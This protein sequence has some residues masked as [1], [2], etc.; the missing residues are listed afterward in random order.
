MTLTNGFSLPGR[1][2]VDRAGEQPFPGPALPGDQHGGIRVLH[3]LD[4]VEDPSDPRRLSDDVAERE[5]RLPLLGDPLDLLEAAEGDDEAVHLARLARK[6]RPARGDG[7]DAAVR[8]DEGPLDVD[9]GL[10]PLAEL[11][12]RAVVLRGAER[13]AKHLAAI[14]PERILPRDPHQPLGGPVERGDPVVPADGDHRLAQA[15]QDRRELPLPGERIHRGRAMQ[16]IVASHAVRVYQK[17]LTPGG[18]DG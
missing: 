8:P 6:E 10:P 17:T 12:H 4:E 13:G 9:P 11:P 1:Q 3:H 18:A 5:F 7:N 14:L 2:I 15:V 16:Q